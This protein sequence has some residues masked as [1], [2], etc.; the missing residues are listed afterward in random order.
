MGKAV[1]ADRQGRLEQAAVA[2][3][4]G[5]L[6][7]ARSE[8]A[9]LL[10]AAAEAAAGQA[11]L[12]VA[13]KDSPGGGICWLS[14][15]VERLERALA[16]GPGLARRVAKRL[17][18]G[19]LLVGCS[20]GEAAL[21][22]VRLQLKVGEEVI[23]RDGV[24]WA[25]VASDGG[26]FEVARKNVPLLACVEVLEAGRLAEDAAGAAMAIAR[27]GLNVDAVIDDGLVPQ[28]VGATVIEIA[29][30]GAG[31]SG[32]RVVRVGAYEER[33]IRKQA[34]LSVLFVCTGNTC[35]S[36]MAEAIAAHLLATR[37]MEA[38]LARVSS[39]GV[40]AGTGSPASVETEAALRALGVSPKRHTSRGLSRADLEGADVVYVM[41]GS[42]RSAVLSLAPDAAGK[43]QLLDPEG[44]DIPD[45]IGMGQDRY[46]STARLMRG[47]I[48][49][50]LGE[51]AL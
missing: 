8:S 44:H 3:R 16:G 5:G 38:D 10:V 31:V 14:P 24:L 26:A 43:V 25:R 36:P 28:R 39:A 51:L 45:P 47:L 20:M 50:R 40:S 30:G 34:R 15:S 21:A 41:T 27:L 17:M 7:L 9:Y 19:P 33:Y 29:G 11:G 37:G 2:L 18:P 46:N 48:D 23:D 42:H 32:L 13:A 22:S 1:A 49:R 35:R 6:I 12:R 4:D